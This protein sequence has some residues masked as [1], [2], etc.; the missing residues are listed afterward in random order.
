MED[1]RL[2]LLHIRLE[3]RLS[4]LNT[5]MLGTMHDALFLFLF[6]LM[7]FIVLDIKLE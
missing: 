4:T 3:D 7:V 5:I 1:S 6:R 2:F